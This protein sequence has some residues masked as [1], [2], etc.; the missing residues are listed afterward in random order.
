MIHTPPVL[1]YG[2]SFIQSTGFGTRNSPRFWVESWTRIARPARPADS[3]FNESAEL[4][5][6]CGACKSE[7]TFVQNGILT[8]DNHD[9]TPVFGT[10]N[11]VVFRRKC[12]DHGEYRTVTPA[13]IPWDREPRIVPAGKARLLE[14]P[15]DVHDAVLAGLPIV[16][17]VELRDP[18]TGKHALVECPVKTMNIDTELGGWQVDTGPV[19]WPDLTR[20]DGCFAD[21][22]RLAYVVFN[23]D[24]YVEAVVE[25]LTDVG[26]PERPARVYHYSALETHESRNSLYAVCRPAARGRG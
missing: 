25:A 6:Q 2:C 17:R 14:G 10:R 1:D 19:A 21:T 16:A 12:D 8:D 11:T 15:D 13:N 22:L 18:G 3:G 26:S 4:Y 7:R 20:I 5:Y 23:T 9:F 24:D